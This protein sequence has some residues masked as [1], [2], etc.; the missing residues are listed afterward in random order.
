MTDITLSKDAQSLVDLIAQ[1]TKL[2]F[3]LA[4]NRNFLDDVR[5]EIDLE[6]KKIIDDETDLILGMFIPAM[7]ST[8]ELLFQFEEEF[9]GGWI[10]LGPSRALRLLGEGDIT[11]YNLTT[12]L[13]GFKKLVQKIILLDSHQTGQQALEQA[14]QS[15]SKFSGSK[16]EAA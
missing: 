16:K 5:G 10:D 14:R 9:G 4:K 7:K 13:E 3:R 11:E 12:F 6:D 8:Y 2:G 15:L 1:L